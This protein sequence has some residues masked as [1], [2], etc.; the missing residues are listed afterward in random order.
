[1]AVGNVPLVGNEGGTLER[2][3]G[4]GKQATLI[5]QNKQAIYNRLK[6][7]FY[8]NVFQQINTYYKDVAK[9][10]QAFEDDQ[11]NAGANFLNTMLNIGTGLIT[12]TLTYDLISGMLSGGSDAVFGTAQYIAKFIEDAERIFDDSDGT[13]WREDLNYTLASIPA[14]IIK[15]LGTAGIGLVAGTKTLFGDQDAFQE[16]AITSGKLEDWANVNIVGAAVKKGREADQGA[17]TGDYRYEGGEIDPNSKAA[18]AYA[19]K[20]TRTESQKKAQEEVN[21]NLENAD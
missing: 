8:D 21:A 7:D 19:E 5:T 18:Q 2:Q 10:Q 17:I 4:K 9:R 12:G 1:M 6:S 14:D 13:G 20:D 15:G 11:K 3:S 16:A